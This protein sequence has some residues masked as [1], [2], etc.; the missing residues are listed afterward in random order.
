[1][2]LKN[3]IEKIGVLRGII[4]LFLIGILLGILFGNAT[5][6]IYEE[7]FTYFVEES[8]NRI[9]ILEQNK[10]AYFISICFQ[11]FQVIFFILLFAFTMFELPYIVCLGIY[12]GFSLGL[13]FTA[14]VGCYGKNGILLVLAYLFPQVIFY[15][16]VICASMVKGYWLHKKIFAGKIK[17]K[18]KVVIEQLP[19]IAVFLFLMLLGCFLET[20]VN[21][22]I[23]KK[24]LSIFVK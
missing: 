2:H 8:Y 6:R 15:A 1:M 17:E 13:F 3:R 19:Y 24:A 18:W 20:N 22:L 5:K 23:V 7:G 10:E 9:E 14:M 4:F 21:I 16:P 12:E 11:R